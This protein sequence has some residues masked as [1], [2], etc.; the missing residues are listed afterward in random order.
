MNRT[1]ATDELL[2]AGI[3]ILM[4]IAIL[5]SLGMVICGYSDS[6]REWRE[7]KQSVEARLPKEESR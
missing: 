6:R 1:K 2:G 5:V 3:G 4:L 7:W